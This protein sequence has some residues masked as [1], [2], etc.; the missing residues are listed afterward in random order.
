MSR[1]KYP[2]GIQTFAEIRENGY[3]YIDKTEF[4]HELVSSGKYYFLSRPRRFGKSLAISTLKAL[5][6]GKRDL[7]KGLAIDSLEWGWQKHEVLH[8]DLNVGNSVDS[9]SLAVILE[10]HLKEWEEK[11]KIIPATNDLANRFS[12]IIIKAYKISGRRVVILVDEF[13]KP[14]PGVVNSR[15][16]MIEYWKQLHGIYGVMKSMDRYIEFGMIFGVS[17]YSEVSIHSTLNNLQDISFSKR[18]NAICGISESELTRYFADDLKA[19]SDE[20]NISV[21]LLHEKLKSNYDGYHFSGKKEDIYNPFSLLSVLKNRKICSY[22]NGLE[23]ASQLLEV[24]DEDTIS[25]EYLEGC[26]AGEN[27]LNGVNALYP[28]PI[29]FL[30]QTGYLTIKDYNPEFKIYTL[31]FPNKEAKEDINI[32]FRRIVNSHKCSCPD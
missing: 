17:S 5:F 26:R 3:I 4:I 27:M 2:I 22:W 23:S 1:V 32:L 11:Y 18:F 6:E 20:L 21:D 10:R 7:F 30:Y 14:L 9:T 25:I 12:D 31:G 16:L 28:D 8:L 24:L 19:W 29:S 15:E 13:S